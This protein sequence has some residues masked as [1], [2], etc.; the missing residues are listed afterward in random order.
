ME[1]ILPDDTINV[2][3]PPDITKKKRTAKVRDP[4]DGLRF[5][6]AL[7]H[8]LGA[9]LG[10]FGMIYL[11]IQT[12]GDV[13]TTIIFGIYGFSMVGLYTASAL[14]HSINTTVTGRINLRKYD[15]C[16]IYLLIAGSY[17][18]ICLLILSHPLGTILC[19]VI[20]TLAMA[21]IF[22]T[23][24]RPNIPRWLSSGIYLFMG[25]LALFAIVPL[26]RTLSTEGLFLLIFGGVLYSIGGVL[27]AVKWPGRD[28][29]RFGCHEIFHVFILLG[30]A[31]HFYM[32]CIELV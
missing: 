12:W 25:W 22:L 3:N 8:G 7:T 10:L 26:S 30:S 17:T 13:E 24:T 19:G 29:P 23:I 28:N 27:Y 14:Y 11:L 4:Y 6:S 20:W 5:W 16:S 9:V 32:M 2:G 18:P 21:G 1:P 15:H 31:A